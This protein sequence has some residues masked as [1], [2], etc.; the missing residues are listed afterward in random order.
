MGLTYW[1]FRD[2][3]AELARFRADATQVAADRAALGELRRTYLR[4]VGKLFKSGRYD[5]R[6][7]DGGKVWYD[8]TVLPN[9]GLCINGPAEK[10]RP[11]DVALVDEVAKVTELMQKLGYGKQRKP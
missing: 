1:S 10:L 5:F 4:K 11:G 6:S 8:C 3:Q 2:S 7:F 9:G